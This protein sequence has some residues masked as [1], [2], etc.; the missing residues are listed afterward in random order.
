MVKVK[1]FPN[2]AFAELAQQALAD[3][4]IPSTVNA[5]DLSV[6]SPVPQGADLWV[7]EEFAERATTFVEELFGDV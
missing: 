1:N 5:M 2:R 6:M 4:G 3:E 7:P